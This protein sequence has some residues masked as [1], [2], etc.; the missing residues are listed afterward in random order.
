MKSSRENTS[1]FS[2]QLINL[3]N[4]CSYIT[5]LQVFDD[6]NVL[7]STNVGRETLSIQV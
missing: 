1:L 5:A 2:L 7:S 4:S 6:K 3:D